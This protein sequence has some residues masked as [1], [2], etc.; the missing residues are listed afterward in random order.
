MP[1]L[2]H[3]QPPTG[4]ARIQ[5]ER[6]SPFEKQPELGFADNKPARFYHWIYDLDDAALEDMVFLFDAPP[7]GIG[8]DV[9]A[10]LNDAIDLWKD[11][12]QN[13]SLDVQVRYDGL[14]FHDARAGREPRVVHVTDRDYVLMYETLRKPWSAD[15][16]RNTLNAGRAPSAE[17]SA[18][19]VQTFLDEFVGLGLLFENCGK[20]VALACAARRRAIKGAVK[21]SAA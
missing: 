19:A 3:L 14:V 16:L 11:A 8:G 9:A 2:Y 13:S 7:A 17:L 12:Y 10:A 15:G 5:I 21:A 4:A 1:N 20:Y 6:F 18:E